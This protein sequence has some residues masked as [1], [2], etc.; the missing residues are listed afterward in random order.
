MRILCK[1]SSIRTSSERHFAMKSSHTRALLLAL[2]AL[3]VLAVTA[4]PA[5]ARVT[6]AGAN[7][8]ATSSDTSLTA[9]DGSAVIRCPTAEITANVDAMGTGLTGTILFSRGKRLTC[10]ARTP[11]GTFSVTDIGPCR[12]R[13][14][15]TASVAGTSAS[16]TITLQAA[17]IIRIA[18]VGDVS[19]DA[20][21]CQNAAP[22]WTLSQATQSID[23]TCS[24]TS[25]RGGTSGL[26]TFTGTFSIVSVNRRPTDPARRANILTIS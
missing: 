9:D 14:E 25:T 10:E 21:S 20:Q 26:N 13:L 6:P 24:L 18:V 11:L 15:S 5:Q 23:V 1:I 8:S 17:C 22:N 4:S 7:V 19:V 12:V 16:G 2:G 3:V